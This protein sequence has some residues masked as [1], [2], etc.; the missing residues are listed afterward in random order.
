MDGLAASIHRAGRLPAGPKAPA[1]PRRWTPPTGHPHPLRRLGT[2]PGPDPD[3]VQR[4][5]HG[6]V[7]PARGTGRRDGEPQVQ[8]PLIQAWSHGRLAA[9]SRDKEVPA[10]AATRRRDPTVHRSDRPARRSGH[11]YSTRPPGGPP[12]TGAPC[13]SRSAGRRPRTRQARGDAAARRSDRDH[14]QPDRP[15]ERH[16]PVHQCSSILRRA[17]V[18]DGGDHG[19]HPAHRGRTR[20]R[21]PG[22]QPVAAAGR[23][24]LRCG[25]G[26]TPLA[27]CPLLRQGRCPLADAAEL[28]VFACPLD[29]PL[30][31]RSYRG[32]H[33]LH[34]YRAHPDYGRLPLVLVT[35]APPQDLKG[36]GPTE[37]VETFTEPAVVVA[38]V[39][40]LLQPRPVA[41]DHHGMRRAAVGNQGD[42]PEARPRRCAWTEGLAAASRGLKRW[43]RRARRD[44]D[45]PKRASCGP[46]FI[47]GVSSAWWSPRCGCSPAAAEVPSAGRALAGCTPGR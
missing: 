44:Q 16:P 42:H 10:Q 26:P 20:R 35:V 6:A 9:A 11:G 21:T 27:A 38:A 39:H 15:T 3:P 23:R 22:H 5:G 25:G 36:P 17:A 8:G 45:N 34:A 28:L 41:A 12:L 46:A 4:Q 13:F 40:R 43:P 7:R 37:M 19:Q 24:V 2:Q 32:I 1:S 31:G 33:L 18:L 29:L 30:R 14:S 47:P